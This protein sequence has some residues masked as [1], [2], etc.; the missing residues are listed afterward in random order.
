[1]VDVGIKLRGFLIK[2]SEYLM[3]LSENPEISNA[4]NSLIDYTVV[5]TGV[6]FLLGVAIYYYF[7][8]FGKT[9]PAPAVKAETQSRETKNTTEKKY[10]VATLDAVQKLVQQEMILIICK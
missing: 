5:N 9:T 10:S 4:I 7:F 2:F 3:A 8:M 1:M 6:A